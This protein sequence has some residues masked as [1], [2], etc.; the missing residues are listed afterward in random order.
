M[1]KFIKWLLSWFR[2][3]PGEDGLSEWA[4]AP[5][6]PQAITRLQQFDDDFRIFERKK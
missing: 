3:V 5:H 6:D 4:D 1:R 2:S